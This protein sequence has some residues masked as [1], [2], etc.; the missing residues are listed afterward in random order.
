MRMKHKLFAA[1][2][3]GIALVAL[4]AAG[5]AVGEP[6]GSGEA[7]ASAATAD[8]SS[9]E[10]LSDI[11]Q[12]GEVYPLE[13]E[14]FF[15][16]YDLVKLDG[17]AHAH[18]NLVNKLKLGSKRPVSLGCLSCKGGD[19]NALYAEYGDSL[20]S[21]TYPY[22]TDE[23][24]AVIYDPEASDN[25]DANYAVWGCTT[26]HSD[27]SD[28]AGSLGAT[29]MYWEAIS[30]DFPDSVATE[31]EVCGQCHN[32]D[33]SYRFMVGGGADSI[34]DL[35]AY[36]Y[37]IDADSWRKAFFENSAWGEGVDEVGDIMRIDEETGV[38]DIY[39][40]HPDIE[41]YQNSSH[42]SLGVTCVDCHMVEKT[43]LE[44]ETYTSHS[45]SM[46]PLTSKA[47]L[48]YCLTCHEAQGITSAQ[49]MVK[50]VREKQQEIVEPENAL[51]AS[52]DELKGLIKEAQE[53]GSVDEET[54]Q[55]ARD[56]WSLAQFYYRWQHGGTATAGIKVAM[57]NS[58]AMLD[59]IARGQKLVDE[60]IA[61]F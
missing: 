1:G 14:S 59:Y 38:L 6:A 11:S 48:E 36:K 19:I 21:M 61:L 2:V 50:W 58:D 5:V 42:A 54:L 31:N 16:D 43:S 24:A 34:Y 23:P 57:Y 15:A 7:A 39:V 20:F 33:D 10:N 56:N 8:A 27:A 53:S 12:W 51:L 49:A 17:K 25:S 18:S 55:Q 60:A 3:T 45:A 9:I 13:Y 35:S 52:L 28:P 44:G 26:C 4:V 46:S 22:D 47:A 30:V 29:S 32:V 41:M 40:T 37:G